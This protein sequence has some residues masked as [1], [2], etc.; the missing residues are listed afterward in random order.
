MSLKTVTG[1]STKTRR[2]I[3]NSETA[4]SVLEFL[5]TLPVDERGP[6]LYIVYVGQG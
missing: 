5:H 6:L 4:C 3:R 1:R 2:R